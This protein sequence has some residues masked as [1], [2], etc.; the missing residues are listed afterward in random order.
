MRTFVFEFA[1]TM[2][3]S[4]PFLYLYSEARGGE[5]ISIIDTLAIIGL[6]YLFR[7]VDAGAQ[8]EFYKK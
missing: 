1:L 3:F 4:C 5:E 2:M 8:R 6:V 7:A